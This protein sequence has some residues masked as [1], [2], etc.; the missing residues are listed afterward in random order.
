MEIRSHFD[1]R[2]IMGLTE[3]VQNAAVHRN[4]R[5]S[6][7]A[8]QL[9]QKLNVCENGS[10]QRVYHFLEISTLCTTIL[11]CVCVLPGHY[12]RS[13]SVLL[14]LTPFTCRNVFLYCP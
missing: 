2:E 12:G 6:S 11:L 9:H 1:K 10:R 13:W 14:L 8:F 4:L 7:A 5:D 3:T